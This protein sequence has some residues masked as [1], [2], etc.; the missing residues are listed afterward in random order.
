MKKILL[1]ILVAALAIATLVSCDESVPEEP[2]RFDGMA[3]DAL[4]SPEMLN[5]ATLTYTVK[6]DGGELQIVAKNE[7]DGFYIMNN[8]DDGY[9]EHKNGEIYEYV[10]SGDEWIKAKVGEHGE[11]HNEMML[12]VDLTGLFDSFVQ[13]KASGDYTAES[14]S[15]DG[16]QITAVTVRISGGRLDT[17]SFT[18]DGDEYTVSYKDYGTTDISFPEARLNEGEGGDFELPIIRK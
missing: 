12:I 14:V 11:A 6:G 8:G 4:F 18:A 2:Q 3:W 16:E 13:D 17:I 7:S 15:L 10:K 5:N 1:F 9:C